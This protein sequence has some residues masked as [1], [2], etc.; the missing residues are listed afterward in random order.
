M[1][2]GIH[3]DRVGVDVAFIACARNFIGARPWALP[4]RPPS[5]SGAA[6]AVAPASLPSQATREASSLNA[7][8]GQRKVTDRILV[9]AMRA[10]RGEEEEQEEVDAGRTVASEHNRALGG[11]G[12]DR[13]SR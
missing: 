3:S 9:L 5:G 8:R 10:W 12:C 4:V 11:A 7:R 2:R 13:G 1:H 6:A